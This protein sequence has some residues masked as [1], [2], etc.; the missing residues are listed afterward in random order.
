MRAGIPPRPVRV[1]VR[2]RKGGHK[3]KKNREWKKV[4]DVWEK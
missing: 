1:A 3:G 4:K 2:G